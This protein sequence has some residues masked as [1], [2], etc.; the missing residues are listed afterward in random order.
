ML[1][2]Q[3]DAAIAMLHALKEMGVALTIDDFGTGYSSLSYLRRL[4]LDRLKIDR[5]FIRDVATSRDD[6]AIVRAIVS[7][8]H[9]LHLKVIAEGV[10][11]PE[12]LAFLH[13]LG[14]DQ[15]QGYHFSAP[16]PNNVFVSLVREHQADA[17]VARAANLEDTW[18]KRILRNA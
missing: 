9:N 13:E 11:T 8:A 7:L 15:Y 6:V 12:Q 18:V 17:A 1:M 10:E 16:V 4:P 14:C 5:A 2:Q 3:G